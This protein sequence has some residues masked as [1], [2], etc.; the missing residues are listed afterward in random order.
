MRLFNFKGVR[1]V[2]SVL[3]LILFTLGEFHHEHK[4]PHLEIHEK[5]N[6][7]DHIVV[8]RKRGRK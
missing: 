1:V 8:N 5:I 6:L 7:H 3:T 2:M 4:K